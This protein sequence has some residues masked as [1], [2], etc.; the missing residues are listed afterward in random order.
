LSLRASGAFAEVA[1]T[2]SG[3]YWLQAAH[4]PHSY[5]VAGAERVF[6]ALAPALP[7]G[8]PAPPRLFEGDLPYLIVLEDAATVTA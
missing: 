4:D 5:G 7:P 6:R 3:S 1:Q 8:M 2:R